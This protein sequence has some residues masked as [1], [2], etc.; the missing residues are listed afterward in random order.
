VQDVVRRLRARG[1]DKRRDTWRE[2]PLDHKLRDELETYDLAQPERQSHLTKMAFPD[3]NCEQVDA[4]LKARQQRK[5][6]LLAR[7][8]ARA[9][10]AKLIWSF[11]CREEGTQDC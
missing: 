7:V 2:M 9:H 8:W 4:A 3:A 1:F 5:S 6:A 11:H 10:S